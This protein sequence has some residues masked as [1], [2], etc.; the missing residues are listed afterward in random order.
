MICFI[1]CI[2]LTTQAQQNRSSFTASGALK[3]MAT[4]QKSANA[5]TR[6]M[7]GPCGTEAGTNTITLSN[8]QANDY[9]LCY[10]D[11]IA[12]ESND[13]YVLYNLSFN[14]VGLGYSVYGCNPTFGDPAIDPCWT[15]YYLTSED[16]SDINLDDANYQHFYSFLIANAVPGFAVPS[17]NTVYFA[18]I[19]LDLVGA[20]GVNHNNEGLGCY[21]EGDVFSIVYLDEITSTV[22][23]NCNNGNAIVTIDISGGYPEQFGT[24]F[25]YT[26]TSTGAGTMVQSGTNGEILTFTNFNQG[27]IISVDIIDDNNGCTHSVSYTSTCVIVTCDAEA[28]QW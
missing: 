12:V 23:E 11:T 26:V 28:G 4:G 17:N 3:V 20:N 24:P 1:A 2:C 10:G 22:N 25:Q 5:S 19:T 13:D 8:Q 14:Q 7:M 21:D 15:G 16:F 27:D 18:P 6:S 9:V